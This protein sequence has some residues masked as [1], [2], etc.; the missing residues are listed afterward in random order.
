M[1]NEVSVGK[2]YNVSGA[3]TMDASNATYKMEQAYINMDPKDI[4][5]LKDSANAS[6]IRSEAGLEV[7]DFF[8][9]ERTGTSGTAFRD[10]NGRV[11]IAYTGTNTNDGAKDIS[12]DVNIAVAPLS[13]DYNPA[14]DFYERVEAENGQ[15]PVVTGHS[16]GGNVAQRVALHENA[17]EAVTYNAAALEYS[18][19]LEEV[20]AAI[21]GISVVALRAAFAFPFPINFAIAGVA[22]KTINDAVNM[23]FLLKPLYMAY[24]SQIANEKK[25]YTG[26]CVN[27]GTPDDPLSGTVA[28][29]AGGK[30][31]GEFKRVKGRAY[32]N[33]HMFGDFE[34]SL[35]QL[36]REEIE[37]TIKGKIADIKYKKSKLQAGGYTQAEKIYID[38]EQARAIIS[39]LEEICQNA[40]D[41]IELVGAQKVRAADDVYTNLNVMGYY[42]HINT[43]HL[44]KEEI[45]GI[46]AEVG[47]TYETTVGALDDE[48][49]K[50]IKK[51]QDLANRYKALE[52]TAKMAFDSMVG[53]DEKLK[54][55]IESLMG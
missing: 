17:P 33:H 28:S 31:L 43:S 5:K 7:I 3:P 52:Q 10:A 4:D 49:N 48:K 55:E 54:R 36:R 44:S 41:E 13:I 50:N 2:I 19:S 37:R 45:H 42:S 51:M 29:I 47:V 35:D 8:Y 53:V 9:D 40:L 1:S 32:G 34:P 30:Y 27:Y 25:Q 11:I 20:V 38:S 15:A 22:A 18:C 23:Y 39:G 26:N 14:Y 21:C 24:H 46:L 6:N 12:T 16:L